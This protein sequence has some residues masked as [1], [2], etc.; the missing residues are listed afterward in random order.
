ME[1]EG[2]A[3]Q[4]FPAHLIK[5]PQAEGLRALSASLLQMQIKSGL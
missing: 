3:R 1:R 5:S 2:I 4:T